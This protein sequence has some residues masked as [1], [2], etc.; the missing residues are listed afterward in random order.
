[1]ASLQLVC[2]REIT[3]VS[4][5][6]EICL[7][8]P[9][10]FFEWRIR[11]VHSLGIAFVLYLFHFFR[12]NNTLEQPNYAKKGRGLVGQDYQVRLFL[13]FCRYL[14]KSRLKQ[15]ATKNLTT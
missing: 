15:L 11:T 14:N 1:M 5:H 2:V 10:I 12:F 13:R 6:A 3:R 9:Y 4:C 7:L 8:I